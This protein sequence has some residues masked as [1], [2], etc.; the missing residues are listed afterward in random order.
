MLFDSNILIYSI[1]PEHQ[2]L[3]NW[4]INSDISIS[5][6]TLLEILGYPRLTSEDRE[7]FN[8]LFKLTETYSISLRVINQAISLRQLKKMTLGDAIIAATALVHSQPLVTRNTKDFE[9][10]EEL[11]LINPF[12]L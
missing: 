8:Q 3:R 2:N 12:D 5:E 11:N 6:I 1:Q 9:W 7:D 10:I 4:V